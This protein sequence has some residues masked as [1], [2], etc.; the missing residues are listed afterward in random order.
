MNPGLSGSTYTLRAGG[1]SS[2]LIPPSLLPYFLPVL[3]LMERKSD[4]QNHKEIGVISPVSDSQRSGPRLR[5]T[6]QNIPP[7]SLDT[8]SVVYL[9]NRDNG[10]APSHGGSQGYLHSSPWGTLFLWSRGPFTYPRHS[11]FGV[12][13]EQIFCPR[14]PDLDIENN[15]F[16]LELTSRVCR[17]V[18]LPC[19]QWAR[20]LI[21]EKHSAKTIIWKTVFL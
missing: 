9:W 11:I 21:V 8:S 5:D 12:T 10:S 7:H 17:G 1:L 4:R 6:L 19:C 15:S 2:Q 20:E 16:Y 13:E 18:L 14:I 3:V